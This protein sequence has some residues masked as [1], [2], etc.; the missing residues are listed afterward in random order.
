MTPSEPGSIHR[1]AASGDSP[2]TSCRYWAMKT[3]DPNTTRVVSVKVAS[4]TRKAG[5]RNSRRSISGSASRRC[6]RT[7]TAPE[8]QPQHDRQQRQPAHALPG[9]TP[10]CR[11]SPPAPPP[12][13]APR[14][15]RSSR[16]A[17]GSRY[18]GSS[19]GPSTSSNT[20]TGTASRNTDPHQKC[21]SITPPSSGPMA[22]PTEKLVAHTPMAA[23]RC[24]GIQEHVAD[25]RQRGRRQGGAGDAQ[26]GPG[27]DQHAGAGG[28][29]GHHRGHPEGRGPH[30]QQPAPADAVAQRAHGGQEPG[31]QEAVDVHDPQQLRAGGLQIRAQARQRQVQHRQIHGVE[32]AGQGD[33]GE[34][35]PLA[36]PRPGRG[37]PG[38][39]ARRCLTLPVSLLA[40]GRARPS[41]LER[42]MGRP[43]VD[44]PGALFPPTR[45]APPRSGGYNAEG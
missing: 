25:E 28:E 11:R 9:R 14:C 39:G 20:I 41:M 27:G 43:E 23:V 44:R 32:Q 6:R 45:P 1:P 36:P 26:Q 34:A 13:T 17:A 35:D 42:R 21:C 22:P 15:S 8:R 38:A 10:S 18:S 16:P 12:A 19:V 33:H 29:G 5:T 40:H 7:N 24:R 4:E 37:G 30:Q 2:S 3:Y 31:H